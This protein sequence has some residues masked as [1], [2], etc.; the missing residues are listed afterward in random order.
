MIYSLIIC[1]GCGEDGPVSGKAFGRWRAHVARNELNELGW[2]VG[3]HGTDW[4]PDCRKS[5]HQKQKQPKKET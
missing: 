1:D 5:T 2:I 3:K 4:C